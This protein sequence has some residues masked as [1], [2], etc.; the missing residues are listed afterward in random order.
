MDREQDRG[1]DRVGINM[2]DGKTR[3]NPLSSASISSVLLKEKAVLIVGGND[4]Q[5]QRLREFVKGGK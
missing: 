2:P 3:I 1:C 4:E 5:L